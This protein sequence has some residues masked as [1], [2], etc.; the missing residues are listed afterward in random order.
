MT[1]SPSFGVSLVCPA[2]RSPLAIGS[3]RHV[4][5]GAD[6]RLAFDVR[7]GLPRLVEADALVLEPADW[8]TAN[9]APDQHPDREESS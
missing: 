3:M 2:C 6:C 5:R 4:C 8:E 1:D 7:D 9:A